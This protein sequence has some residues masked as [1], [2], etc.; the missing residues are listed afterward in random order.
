M[1]RKNLVLL[2]LLCLVGRAAAQQL[3]TRLYTT[4]DGLARNMVL[5]IRRDTRGRLWFCTVEGLSVFDGERFFSY[6]TS[7]GLPHRVVEDILDAGGGVYFLATPAGLFRFR[8][9]TT[10]PASLEKV[11]LL[12]GPEGIRATVLL[13]GSSGEIWCGASH[14]L[15]RV[16][17]TGRLRAEHVPV[18]ASDVPGH[19]AISDLNALADDGRGSLWIGAREGLFRYRSGATTQFREGCSTNAVRSLHLSREGELWAAFAGSVSRLDLRREPPG[20]ANYCFEPGSTRG[21]AQSIYE[22]QDGEIW[23]GAKGLARFRPRHGNRQPFEFFDPRS[24]VGSQFIYDIAEDIAGNRWLALQ[25]SG[26]LRVLRPG[27]SQFAESDGLESRYV[28]SVF[29]SHEGTLYVVT[30]DRHTLNRFDGSRFHPVNVRVPPSVTSFG[31]GEHAVAL[32]DRYGDWWIATGMGLLRYT[33]VKHVEDLSSNLPV[34]RFDKTNGLPGNEITRL[35]ED[36]DGNIW[37]GTT[38]V[39]RWKRAGSKLEDMTSALHKALGRPVSLQSL[40]EDRSGNIWM[41]LYPGGLVRYRAGR[42]QAVAE[43][44]PGGTINSLIV[45]RDGRLWVGSSMGGVARID[46]P[47]DNEPHL[48]FPIEKGR[49]RSDNILQLAGDVLGRIYIAGG[50]GVDRL[51]PVAKSVTHFAADAGPPQAETN[52]LFRDRH[53]AIWFGAVNG[54]ARYLPMPDSTVSPPPP[55][56]HEIR[57]SGVQSLAS[58]EGESQVEIAPFPAGRGVVEVG[59]GSVGFSVENPVR[60]RYRLL[61]V[62][63]EWR[64]PDTGRSVRF[65]GLEPDTYRFEVQAVSS[66]G[67][68]SA[69]SAAVSFRVQGPFWKTWWFFALAGACAAGSVYSLGLMRLRHILA[70]ERVRAHLAADLHDD[71][72]SGLAEIAILTEVANQRG[73]APGLDLIA[74]RARELRQAMSDIVWAVDPSG[75]KLQNLIDRW[76]QTA[77]ALLGED[78]LEFI[79]PKPAVLAHMELTSSERRDLLLLFK[80]IVTNVARHAIAE[81]VYI[82][83]GYAQGWLKLEIVDNGAGFDT[84]RVHAGNGLKNIRQR[85]EDLHGRVVIESCPSQGTTVSLSIPLSHNRMSM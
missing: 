29:E 61:P 68:A 38:G 48:V 12:D 27:F 84:A 44:L 65:A 59:F 63:T 35:Y 43:G 58:D 70:M 71:L 55:V 42:W 83:V 17:E 14:G 47:D 82:Y 2:W 72:G 40:A 20:V 37:I 24:V 81:R 46:H 77:Y 25:R 34:A 13:R 54:L 23:M 66:N 53:G 76:R 79:A 28:H 19:P 4:E 5:R 15:W 16:A 36:R 31:S 7:E 49:L 57:V 50:R 10:Q 39:A 60:Y 75:D 1:L 32:R 18:V 67:V 51:D 80:E 69:T 85:V 3:V 9:R 26:V 22:F 78:H 41:G 8:P 11:P 56:I 52:I 73:S 21:D 33:H 64:L 62:E 74:R 6:T 45:D 30:G